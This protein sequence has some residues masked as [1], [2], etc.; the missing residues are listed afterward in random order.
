VQQQAERAQFRA[1]AVDGGQKEV[2]T[3]L[4]GPAGAQRWAK[5]WLFVHFFEIVGGW[6]GQALTHNERFHPSLSHTHTHTHTYTH[7]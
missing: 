3:G 7:I 6:V 4:G 1:P 5:G 2:G